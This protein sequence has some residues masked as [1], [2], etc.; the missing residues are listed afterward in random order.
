M[1]TKSQ[2]QPSVPS[3]INEYIRTHF[4][5]DYLT[6][7]RPFTDKSGQTA[8][9]VDVTHDSTVYHLRFDKDG[10]L[11]EQVADAIGYPGED[12]EIGEAD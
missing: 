10:H 11:I 7:I 6:N 12:V 4:K 3:G 8:W 2:Q 5:D 1:E 9:F